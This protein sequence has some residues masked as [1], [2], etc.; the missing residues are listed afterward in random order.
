[1]GLKG[2]LETFFVRT[3]VLLHNLKRSVKSTKSKRMVNVTPKKDT[4]VITYKLG[5]K[6][7]SHNSLVASFVSSQQI[8]EYSQKLPLLNGQCHEVDI[9]KV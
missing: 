7:H 1:M 6:K 5:E 2:S 9:F 8:L 3:T 4:L